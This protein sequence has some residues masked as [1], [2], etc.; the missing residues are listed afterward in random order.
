V[1]ESWGHKRFVKLS[2]CNRL[3]YAASCGLVPIAVI[4][5]GL[6]MILEILSMTLEI[7]LAPLR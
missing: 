1:F 6:C 7:N 2:D 3:H 4:T 5:H